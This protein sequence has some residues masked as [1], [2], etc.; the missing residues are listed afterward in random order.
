MENRKIAL[1]VSTLLRTRYK[2]EIK[3]EELLHCDQSSLYLPNHQ[4]EVDPMIL[5]AE[6]AK[7]D[8]VVPMISDAYYNLPLVHK[9]MK[10]VG[11]VPVADFDKGHRDPNVLDKMRQGMINALHNGK[12]IVLYPSGQLCNQGY[13][14]VGNKQSAY[15]LIQELGDQ[16][17]IVG[18]RQHG[19]WG[20]IWSRAWWGRSPD[21][22]KVLLRSLFYVLANFIFFVPKR[23]VH[24]EFVDLTAEIKQKARELERREFNKYLED[25]YNIHGEEYARFMKH[26]FYVPKLKK[27]FPKRIKGKINPGSELKFGPLPEENN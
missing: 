2:V 26:F 4:A 20:S 11:A 15:R 21:F 6:I 13:E 19:L 14:K 25:F 22:F 8:D 17:R 3:G 10:K 18:V 16:V 23:S 27:K 7:I 24:I 5:L 1:F 9:F 12:S